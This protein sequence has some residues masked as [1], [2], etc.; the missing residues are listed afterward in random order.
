MSLG[1]VIQVSEGIYTYLQ[2][3][4]SRLAQLAG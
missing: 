1:E 3:D 4:P 2:P